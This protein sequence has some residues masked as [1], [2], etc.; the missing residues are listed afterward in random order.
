MSALDINPTLADALAGPASQASQ[1]V[2]SANTLPAILFAGDTTVPRLL[3]FRAQTLGDRLAL[4]EKDRGIW[5]RYSW[6]HYYQ[7]VRRVAL[8]LMAFGVRRGDRIAIASENTPEWFYADLAG[9]AI[10]AIVVGIYP[11]NPWPELQYIVGHCGAKV[12]VAGDQEQADKILDAMREGPG[13]PE[14]ER[15]VGVDMKGMRHYRPD[16][17]MS[18]EALL[19]LGDRWAAE[20]P[21]AQAELDARIESGK[22]DDVAIMVYTSGTT[23]PPKGSMITHRNLLWSAFAY[24]EACDLFAKPFEA[25]CYLPL[26]HMAERGN[27]TIMQLV[28]AGR[29]NFAESID[30]VAV[31]VREIAP[32]YFIGVPRIYEKLQQGFMFKLEESGPIQRWAF[33]LAMRLGRLLSD[34]RQAAKAGLA[35]RLLFALLYGLMFR[36]LHRA[37]G[38]DRTHHR[39]CAGAAISPEM[40]RFFD[41]IGLPLSQG[42]GLTECAGV[43]FI[44]RDSHRRIGATGLPIRG[45]EWRR[46]ADN[47]VLIRSPGVFKGYYKDEAASGATIDAEGWLHSGDIVETLD[48]GEIAV[49]DRKK[50]II[51]T[52]GGKN[53]APSELENALKDSPYIRETIVVGEAR[54]FVGA[55]IQIDVDTVGRWARDKG[56]AYTTYKSL[57]L[58][59]EVR[60]LVDS[61][62]A[63][64]NGRFARVENIRRF[65]LLEKEL[66]HDDGEL[67]ATQK[68]RRGIIN[69][70]FAKELV[71]IYGE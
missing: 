31:N 33:G 56:L 58:L 8:G 63:E 66:D 14:V 36:N 59:P 17:L 3:R 13:L 19:A 35:D 46:E 45:V 20:N 4:R 38:L 1:P 18:F 5:R 69:T 16:I 68:V 30:T 41:I 9:Q 21:H 70:K 10:G 32:T 7:T 25:V 29:I 67:T 2:L 65:V 42:Y 71:A 47:E 40:V 11:T 44:Q 61:V 60:A 23:G 55:L 43:A 52:S 50:A 26:C 15:I 49:V 12:V 6:E 54:K 27:S 48:N 34:R 53:I 39:L 24:A 62:V 51:I 37:M 64:V 22:P 28:L 57:T